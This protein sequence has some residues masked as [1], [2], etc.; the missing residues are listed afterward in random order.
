[1]VGPKL[2]P[3]PPDEDADD[4]RDDADRYKTRPVRMD[5]VV[6]VRCVC[7]GSIIP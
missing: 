4:D 1:M 6:I 2:R 7:H 5:Q 3:S